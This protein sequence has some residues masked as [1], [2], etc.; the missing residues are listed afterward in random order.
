[1]AET[2]ELVISFSDGGKQRQYYLAELVFFNNREYAIFF[3]LDKDLV[4][5][6]FLEVQGNILIDID[7]ETEYN[8]LKSYWDKLEESIEEEKELEEDSFSPTN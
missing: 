4:D 5:P 2:E 8:K 6:I 3:S 7:D 1:M